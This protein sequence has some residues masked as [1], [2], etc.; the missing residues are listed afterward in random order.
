MAC[1]PH[2]ATC[3]LYSGPRSSLDEG[4]LQAM[5]AAQHGPPQAAAPAARSASLGS[6]LDVAEL[7]ARISLLAPIPAPPTEPGGAEGGGPRVLGAGGSRIQW[8]Q[9][10]GERAG[11]TA[12]RLG[13]Q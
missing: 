5:A 3:R 6:S 7:L 10:S 2:A 4:L 12:K 9:P 8:V 13:G 1:S 11:G